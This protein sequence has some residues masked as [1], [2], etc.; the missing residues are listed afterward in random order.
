MYKTKCDYIDENISVTYV[1]VFL[2]NLERT[3][4]TKICYNENNLKIR[5]T[6]TM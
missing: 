6:T 2:I 3:K 5:S 1:L 4:G